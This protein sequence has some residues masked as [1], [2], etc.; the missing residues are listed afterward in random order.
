MRDFPWHIATLEDVDH[1]FE[2]YPV[3]V[4]QHFDLAWSGTLDAWKASDKLPYIGNAEYLTK[5]GIVDASSMATFC[6]EHFDMGSFT[7]SNPIV[8]GSLALKGDLHCHTTNSDGA[9]T[10]TEM[11]TAYEALGFDFAAITDHDFWT[12]DPE[13]AGIL[14]IPGCEKTDLNARH[15][16]LF[17]GSVQQVINHIRW[18]IVNSGTIYGPQMPA[19]WQRGLLEIMNGMAGVDAY[20]DLFFD[21]YNIFDVVYAVV[22]SDYH[23]TPTDLVHN[24][25][26]AEES[27]VAAILAALAIGNFYPSTGNNISIS[28]VGN[29]ITATST[30]SS[31]FEFIG[32]D[33]LVL[34]TENGV[35]S[36]SYSAVGWERYVRIVSTRASDSKKAW[37]QPIRLVES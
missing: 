36:S 30:E 26:Y 37:S 8:G 24:I 5:F 1:L 22:G 29:E 34:K 15:F 3:Q 23:T 2:E 14:C 31:N 28:L 18:T 20:N 12:P 27:S 35:L 13:V 7:L 10:P 6:A 25:V 9:K 21:Y 17:T 11:M 4:Q 16:G 33:G 32:R 19:R